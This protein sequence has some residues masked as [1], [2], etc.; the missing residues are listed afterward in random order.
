MFL[1]KTYGNRKIKTI[2]VKNFFLN[3]QLTVIGWIILY[4]IVLPH[5]FL[6]TFLQNLH[7]LL[8]KSLTKQVLWHWRIWWWCSFTLCLQ[9][10][11]S[12]NTETNEK[13]KKWSNALLC[14][15]TQAIQNITVSVSIVDTK[16]NPKKAPWQQRVTSVVRVQRSVPIADRK[17]CSES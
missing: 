16:P 2:I 7:N 9:I 3:N 17:V 15:L 14:L 5:S 4:S 8:T 10:T 12:R 1:Y 13:K 11:N 6:Y